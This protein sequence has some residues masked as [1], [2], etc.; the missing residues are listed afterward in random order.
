MSWERDVVPSIKIR[1]VRNLPEL[2]GFNSDR[3]PLVI[4]YPDVLRLVMTRPV[5]WIER[6]TET[7]YA[8]SQSRRY[9][10]KALLNM[11][12]GHSLS[13]LPITDFLWQRL[14]FE[15]SVRCRS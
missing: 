2:G 8:A 4:E 7:I 14:A 3:N 1:Y 11:L 13:R 10:T 5:N 6:R 12:V 9:P 15:R